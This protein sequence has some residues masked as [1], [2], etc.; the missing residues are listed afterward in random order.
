[1]QT[2]RGQAQQYSALRMVAQHTSTSGSVSDHFWELL[3][4]HIFSLCPTC[5]EPSVELCFCTYLLL[6]I[7]AM[8]TILIA[9]AMI[10]SQLKT[11]R[12]LQ[13]AC[14]KHRMCCLKSFVFQIPQTMRGSQMIWNLPGKVANQ[15][16][17]A[18]RA[19]Q[20][21]LV[22]TH[23]SENHTNFNPIYLSVVT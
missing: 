16:E 11:L 21:S 22:F 18:L 5:T 19:A 9:C 14:Y 13:V 2:L 12:S 17:S 7:V 8:R 20:V 3:L 1:M 10:L 15:F 4:Q 23:R 6:F